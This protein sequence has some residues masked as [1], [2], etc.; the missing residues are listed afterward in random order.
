[1]QNYVSMQDFNFHYPFIRNGRFWPP[2][3]LS[4]FWLPFDPQGLENSVRMENHSG[5]KAILKQIIMYIKSRWET[6]LS[7]IIQ[8]ILVLNLSMII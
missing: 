5:Y 8:K 7:R 2:H 1:M 4:P 6:N 3:P